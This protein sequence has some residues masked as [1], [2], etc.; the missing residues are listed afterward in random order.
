MV[1]MK[2]SELLLLLEKGGCIPWDKTKN[3]MLNSRD[4]Y[5]K[6]K[7]YYRR[8]SIQKVCNGI[9]EIRGK[10]GFQIVIEEV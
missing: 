5:I 9:Y 3:F 8:I 7:Y 4:T 2:R 6:L 10:N 1:D